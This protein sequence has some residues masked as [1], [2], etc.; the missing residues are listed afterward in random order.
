MEYD[1]RPAGNFRHGS[2]AGPLP[3]GLE[4]AARLDHP[5]GQIRDVEFSPDG[6]FIGAVGPDR[7]SIW[8][9]ET[10]ALAHEIFIAPLMGDQRIGVRTEA[11]SFAWL[12]DSRHIMVQGSGRVGVVD[13]T[14]G[15]LTWSFVQRD[16][17]GAAAS[18]L[19]DR[20]AISTAEDG[21]RIC[22]AHSG[23]ILKDLVGHEGATTRM[24]WSPDGRLL[25]CADAS[26]G[27]GF[28]VPSAADYRDR[29]RDSHI[30]FWDTQS[31]RLYAET[32][33][34]HHVD[35]LRWSPQGNLLASAQR[36][37]SVGLWEP[38]SGRLVS[39]VEMHTSGASGLTFT[40]DGG[41]LVSAS[42]DDTVRFMDIE[43]FDDLATIQLTRHWSDGWIRARF[44]PDGDLLAVGR[45][46]EVLLFRSNLADVADAG[47]GADT[48]RY[49]TA[50]LVLVG[51]SGVGK[52]GLGWRLSH[53]EF[54]EHESTH[55]QQ[56]WVVDSLGMTRSDGTECEAVV[57][58]LAGQHVYRPVHVIFLDRVDLA[59]VVFDPTNRHETLKGVDFWLEQLAGRGHLPPTVL[60]GGRQDR[61]TT[62]LSRAD[63][64]EL[65]RQ[66]GITGG[67]VATSAKTGEGLGDLIDVLQ[68]LI[69]W[70][71]AAATVTTVTFKRIKDYVL[72]LKEQAAR[73]RILV[74]FAQLF[75]ELHASDEKWEF[76]A[77]E[78]RAA[79]GHLETHGY[80]AVLRSS[81]GLELVLLEPKLLPDVASSVILLADRHPRELGALNE[82]LL[83]N[84]GY[85]FPELTALDPLER[86]VLIDATVVRFLRHNVCFR[87]TLGA[88]TLLIFPSLIRQRRPLQDDAETID[89]VSYVARGRVENS[90][91]ALA[92]LLGYA[93]FFKRV[94]QWQD[95]TQYEIERGQ[96]CGLRVIQEREGELEF[97]LSYSPATPEHGRAMFQGLFETFLVQRDV[98][99]TR[100]TPVFCRN[101]HRQARSVVVERR[102]DRR[103]F[104]FCSECGEETPLPDA[105]PVGRA[106]ADLSAKVTRQE[107]FARLRSEYEANLALVKAFVRTAATPRCYVSDA[108]D[109]GA[110]T[111]ELVRSLRDAG[112]D[113]V[114]DIGDLRDSDTV[115]LIC[116]PAYW[117][118]WSDGPDL[119]VL[120]GRLHRGSTA[121]V[122]PLLVDGAPN[123]DQLARL[124]GRPVRDFRD[125]S[126]HFLEL[127][128]LVLDLHGIHHE[129][130][131]FEPLR[132]EMA[133]RWRETLRTRAD[134]PEP[135]TVPKPREVY[136]SYARNDESFAVVNELRTAL[137]HQGVRVIQDDRDI[138]Y[139]GD[140]QEFMRELGS[141]R[142]V[143]LVVSQAYL[144]SE[145]CMFELLEIARNGDLR[146]RIFPVV[147][148]GAGIYKPLDRITHVQY[149]EEQVAKLDAALKTVSAANLDGFRDEMDL[150]SAIRASLPRLGEI[151]KHL[152]ALSPELHHNSGYA[153]LVDSVLR[154]LDA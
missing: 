19:G 93:Q 25:A 14:T 30:S 63:L 51:D 64:D 47:T 136:V 76:T 121:P 87:E 131:A 78:M 27:F 12:P 144:R 85:P 20:V 3:G 28:Q 37:G 34:T 107:D 145:S 13:L 83:L 122:I 23:Q 24:T 92:V 21:I 120:A 67:Y 117:S 150:Y 95:Q 48:V 42:W 149:W 118:A 53:D 72:A 4:L 38:D 52:T 132:K 29:V 127:F 62:V 106:A 133:E 86:E 104:L 84:G 137:D 17:L 129:N 111:A 108:G 56:F 116:T 89:G 123:G 75:R 147:L 91:A 69:P 143:V 43:N 35:D 109:Q 18:P 146:N 73:G 90:Y 41:T 119:P 7:V 6:R 61:G 96:I 138:R 141:G 46:D 77:E 81:A 10:R 26:F 40:P 49:T 135:P 5:A 134:A 152:N 15:E 139:R 126:R 9:V 36:N 124:G 97:V 99:V 66:H 154:T 57:W 60:V 94:T 50:K 45:G 151:L 112:V 125:V 140:I 32:E 98:K 100:F 115:L 74:D 11:T 102:R 114:E 130:P 79:V 44:A 153:E 39:T 68:R 58:D 71:E 33:Q 22:N 142:A 1:A 110:W 65:C 55:G 16:L 59:L 82:T 2:L 88:E 103:G 128:D 113:L 80:V 31:G 70:D 148:P 8:D 54:R 105:E 101:G